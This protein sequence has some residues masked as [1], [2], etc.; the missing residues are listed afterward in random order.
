M[1]Q[2]EAI[3]KKRRKMGDEEQEERKGKK[4]EER[5]KPECHPK[6]LISTNRYP[7]QYY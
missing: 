5:G 1:R 6:I 3:P 4:K 2:L 7:L